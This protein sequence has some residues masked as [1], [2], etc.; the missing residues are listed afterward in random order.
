MT[1]PKFL[2]TVRLMR[3]QQEVLRAAGDRVSLSA[4]D[5]IELIMNGVRGV[6]FDHAE[7]ARKGIAFVRAKALLMRQEAE[8]LEDSVDADSVLARYEEGI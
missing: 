8:D 5:K 3:A 6:R 4:C 1:K 7:E 2:D